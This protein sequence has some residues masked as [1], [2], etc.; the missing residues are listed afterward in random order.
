LEVTN[1][2]RKYEFFK[3]L[4]NKKKKLKYLRKFIL[5]DSN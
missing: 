3:K 5:R 4:E 2:L 1:M